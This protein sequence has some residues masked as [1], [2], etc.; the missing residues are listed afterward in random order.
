MSLHVHAVIDL[1][2]NGMSDVWERRY[3]AEA[4]DPNADY[5]GDDKNCLEES[6]AGTDPY[7]DTSLF[8]VTESNYYPTGVILKWESKIGVRYQIEQSSSLTGQWNNVG[9]R[10][11]GNS[12]E[13]VAAFEPAGNRSTFYRVRI[14]GL[15]EFSGIPAEGISLIE[16]Y[17]HDNDGYNDLLEIRS[18]S[19]PFDR[20]VTLPTPLIYVGS[21]ATVAWK[22][23]KGKLY[24]VKSAI[25]I[26]GPWQDEGVPHSGNG[27]NMTAAVHFQD[28]VQKHLRVTVEDIDSDGDGASDWEE[29]QAGLNPQQPK[30]NTL[31]LDD[32]S[33]LTAMML[34]TDKVS[35]KA[36]GA[37]ANITQMED[38]GF[39]IVREGGMG[40]LVVN[41]SIS[42]TAVAGTDYV[43]LSGSV[44]IPFGKNSVN[45]PVKPIATSGMAIS[46][47]VVM[48]LSSG[49]Y[50]LDAQI[51]Q[52]V[53]V[54]KEVAINVKDYGAVGDGVTDDTTAIQS[55][56]D[57]LEASLTHNTLF[58]PT[59]K[60]CLSRTYYTQHSTGTSHYRILKLGNQDL[61]GRDLVIR[62]E[63]DAIL[64]STISPLRAK[65]LLVMGTFR[66][67]AFQG[68]K[69]E[70]VE[71][72]LSQLDF[73]DNPNG[74]SG[75]ALIDV[76]DR[77]IEA[78][79]FD[80]CEFVNCHRSVT[81]DTAPYSRN[82]KLKL[83][84]FDNCHVLNPYGANTINAWTAWGG[85]Q[86]IFISPWVDRADYRGNYFDG[87][88]DN[89]HETNNPGGV[90][91]DGSHFGSP[92]RLDF[93][94]N[95][96]RRMGVEAVD[97]SNDN[98]LIG[99]SNYS[100]LMPP[101]DG[102]TPVRVTLKFKPDFIDIGTYIVVRA[103]DKNNVLK[104]V[105]LDL[106][107]YAV[108]CVNE[109]Y[110]ENAVP[111]D[112][113]TYSRPVYLQIADPT[114]VRITGNL[115]VTRESV[116]PSG[117]G[118]VANAHG[119]IRNNVIYGYVT[120]IG[121]YEEHHTPLYPSA[122]GMIIDSNYILTRDSSVNT[123]S[124]TYGIYSWAPDQIIQNN[125]ILIPVAT[126][127]VGIRIAG[128]NN[129][130]RM[131]NIKVM[132]KVVNGYGA[133]WMSH[134]IAL[135]FETSAGAVIED[136]R[137]EGFDVGVG[138]QFVTQIIPHWVRRHQSV[139]DQLSV[140]PKGLIVE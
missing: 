73:P 20:Q 74:A 23:E 29:Y 35:L 5:D 18:G 92:L 106:E 77:E 57:A 115:I 96:V 129:W 64:Y 110:L 95:I 136:N 97:Q 139:D 24:R 65:M 119:E 75:V 26:N 91:K 10:I 1:N 100:F 11:E 52:Q 13:L 48:T 127:S 83:V 128:E 40:E 53:N 72:P 134:G 81:I 125:K 32:L 42:G 137:T 16:S 86:Q 112:R 99:Y 101:A 68:L 60:Y 118:I 98:T 50:T 31:R 79:V 8:G 78:L 51:S 58:F 107:N 123:N 76:D 133:Q 87:A 104:V 109:G 45:V 103:S 34:A 38:G 41:Y 55:A 111:G 67:L 135:L 117:I 105:S 7:L 28:G 102:E 9:D 30:T 69:W 17:D 14:I 47:S 3:G 43:A 114:L 25:E 108:Y 33:V 90:L 116:V 80:Q 59:G 6:L 84:K 39:E 89:M 71:A 4:A 138:P 63:I 49:D 122:R 132:D 27:A 70:K 66:S 82:G 62:G 93:C 22:S 94:D 12:G 140:D 56:I 36:S 126:H 88:G 54:I 113:V 15:E 61:A 2:N 120:G 44:I 124:F 46:Q 130:V 121:I 37:V 85:G 131:N 21:T 19:D